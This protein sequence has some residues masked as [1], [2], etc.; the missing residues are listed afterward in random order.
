MLAPVI[1]TAIKRGIREV[2]KISML[3][4][5]VKFSKFISLTPIKRDANEKMSS[6][7][8]K[9]LVLI[10]FANTQ[11]PLKI[12]TDVFAFDSV[13][14]KWRFVNLLQNLRVYDLFWG[15]VSEDFAVFESDDVIAK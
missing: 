2:K 13:N 12:D 1:K 15:A 6:K 4:F 7:S 11:K 3:S 9:I 8:A 5:S 14:F 10:N